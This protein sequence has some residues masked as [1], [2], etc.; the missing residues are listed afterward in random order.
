MVKDV[1]CLGSELEV[2]VLVHGKRLKQAHIEV[3]PRRQIENVSPRGAIG[4]PLG[5]TEGIAVPEP[6]SLNTGWMLHRNWTM[7]RTYEVGIR[8][9]RAS[10]L[11][12]TLRIAAY[13][14]PRTRV[15]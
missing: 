14:V 7:Q 1:K 2:H 3:R 4:E 12:R 15:V 6:G 9:H 10:V 8:L 5:G 13:R 11:D